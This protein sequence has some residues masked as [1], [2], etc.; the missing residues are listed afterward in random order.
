MVPGQPGK[1]RLLIEEMMCSGMFA[2]ADFVFRNRLPLTII[3]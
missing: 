2:P 3:A 1:A